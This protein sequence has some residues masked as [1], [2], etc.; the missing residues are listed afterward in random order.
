[1]V[2]DHYFI[3]FLQEK[4]DIFIDCFLFLFHLNILD[5]QKLG[6]ILPGLI[7]DA[8][9]HWQQRLWRSSIVQSQLH[10]L[11]KT[12]NEKVQFS[13]PIFL[14]KILLMI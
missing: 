12:K 7:Q 2:C 3:L 8:V 11:V 5:S 6:V 1:M 10:E 14:Y 9:H 13:K 4:K